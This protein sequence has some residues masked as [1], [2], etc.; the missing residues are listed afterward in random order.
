MEQSLDSTAEAKNLLEEQLLGED[1]HDIAMD[2]RGA[3][4]Y[5]SADGVDHDGWFNEKD[6]PL[7]YQM[8]DV[9]GALDVT[10]HYRDKG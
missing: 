4:A 5:Q 2:I 1:G 10:P 7:L 3:P 6:E 9:S 8:L